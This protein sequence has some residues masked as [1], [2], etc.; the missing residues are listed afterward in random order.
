MLLYV[1]VL[2]WADGRAYLA[3][4]LHAGQGG[5]LHIGTRTHTARIASRSRS[6]FL[7]WL[8]VSCV[9]GVCAC[10]C[11]A[12]RLLLV[13]IVLVSNILGRALLLQ[14]EILRIA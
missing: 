13:A 14:P 6:R 7:R 9:R 10:S 12:D 11:S 2:G 4:D 3:M 5:G 8:C 1:A